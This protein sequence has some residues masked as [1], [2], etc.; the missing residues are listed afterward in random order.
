MNTSREWNLL[1]DKEWAVID[2]ELC[3]VIEF[4]PL[5][6][7]KEGKIL[8][9]KSLP[10]AVVIL[11]CK[12]VPETI[13]GY[14]THKIDFRN[15]W[16]VFEERT[17]QE[18]EEVIIIWTKQNYKVTWLRYFRVYP[19]LCVMIF[20]KGHFEILA[21]PSLRPESMSVREI[22]TPIE[23]FKPNIMR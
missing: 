21:D 18:N 1:T 23:E 11:E 2:G 14:V 7:I 13:K 12:K 8:G 16:K 9:E 3:R 20:P 6:C 19:K 4:S 15:L 10:Y 17:V 5:S 22:L